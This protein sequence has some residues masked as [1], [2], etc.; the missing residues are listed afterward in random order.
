MTSKKSI[1]LSSRNLIQHEEYPSDRMPDYQ[2]QASTEIREPN[3]TMSIIEEKE[4]EEKEM[5][6]PVASNLWN[7][8]LI[9]ISVDEN[10]DHRISKRNKVTGNSL[11]VYCTD[12]LLLVCCMIMSFAVTITSSLVL[13]Y[14]QY[15]MTSSGKK[16]F[17]VLQCCGAFSFSGAISVLI[18]FK[19]LF[20]PKS[21]ISTRE[22][23]MRKLKTLLKRYLL[24]HIFNFPF[25]KQFLRRMRTADQVDERQSI[26]T[27]LGSSTFNDWTLKKFESLKA[28]PEGIIMDS[29]GINHDEL[30][31]YYRSYILDVLIEFQKL[32][33]KKDTVDKSH[34]PYQLLTQVESIIL[35][36]LS[37]T[38]INT[39]FRSMIHDMMDA[40]LDLFVFCMTLTMAFLG[41]L[42]GLLQAYQIT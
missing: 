13:H 29:I 28:S 31:T 21:P 30:E 35:E 34:D 33:L 6:G 14:Y 7:N 42:F 3:D 23:K 24:Q 11:F 26:V 1:N 4:G 32:Y 37:N 36:K 20:H 38:N 18:S 9:T 41:T 10:T 5:Q 12:H 27:F 19:L 17:K 16:I 39:G 22:R 8:S 25:L 40:H 2:Q 15:S